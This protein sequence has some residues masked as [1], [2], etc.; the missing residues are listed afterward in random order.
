MLPLNPQS[1]VRAAA[2]RDAEVSFRQLLTEVQPPIASR[3]TWASVKRV[4]RVPWTLKP[5]P[6]LQTVDPWT[7][8]VAP[9]H[10]F[11]KRPTW[12]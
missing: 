3:T 5:I 12:L 6:R 8:A 10:T 1:P 2:A 11:L 4:V 7:A 9:E